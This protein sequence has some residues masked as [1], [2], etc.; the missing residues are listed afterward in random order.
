MSNKVLVINQEGGSIGVPLGVGGQDIR[1]LTWQE[2]DALSQQEREGD[3]IF[4]ITDPE[5][6]FVTLLGMQSIMGKKSFLWPADGRASLRIEQKPVSEATA[7]VGLENGDVWLGRPSGA[8]STH[9]RI[10]FRAGGRTVQAVDDQCVQTISGGTTAVLAGKKT[11]GAANQGATVGPV[12]NLPHR[13]DP[14]ATPT[15]GTLANGD[16]WTTTE[17]IKARINGT[18]RTFYHD[19]NLNIPG[20]GLQLVALRAESGL[21]GTGVDSSNGLGV[22]WGTGATQVPRGNDARF[23]D[24]RTPLTHTHLIADLPVAPSGTSNTTQLVRADDS[25]LSNSRAPTNHTHDPIQATTGLTIATGTQN[26]VLGKLTGTGTTPA[27]LALRGTGSLASGLGLGIGTDAPS[28]RTAIEAAP[29]THTHPFGDVNG[30]QTGR[31]LGRTATGTGVA[32]ELDVSAIRTFLGPTGTPSGTTFL[33][34][35]GQWVTPTNTTYTEIG[36]TQIRGATDSTVGLITGRRFKH[37]LDGR[38]H[39]TTQS[40]AAVT[41]TSDTGRTYAVQRAATGDALVVN[42]PWVAG[43]GTPSFTAVSGGPTAAASPA[44]GAGFTVPFVEQETTGQVTIINRTITLPSLGTGTNDA[45]AGNHDHDGRYPR[46]DLAGNLAIANARRLIANIGANTGGGT[47]GDGLTATQRTN[48]RALIGA[49]TGAGTL[50]G[51]TAITNRTTVLTTSPGSAAAPSVDVHTNLVP[52]HPLATNCF[53]MTNG[54]AATTANVWANQ[55]TVRTALGL[56]SPAWSSFGADTANVPQIATALNTTANRLVAT[57]ASG[58]LIP[59]PAITGSSATRPVWIDANGVLQ[60]ASEYPTPGGGGAQVNDLAAHD[61]TFGQ[62]HHNGSSTFASRADHRHSIPTPGNAALTLRINGGTIAAPSWTTIASNFTAN[63]G[64]A[65]NYDITRGQLQIGVFGT[66]AIGSTQLPVHI[67][68]NGVATAITQANLRI[69]LFGTAAIGGLNQPIHLAAN[70]VPTLCNAYPTVNNVTA[71]FQMNGVNLTSFTLNTATAPTVNIP[72]PS[73]PTTNNDW[74]LRTSGTEGGTRA[75]AALRRLPQVDTRDVDQPPNHA[76]FAN[77]GLYCDFKNNT[78]SGLSDGGTFTGVVT[79]VRWPNNTGG[80]SHQLG[81][82]DNGNL[83]IRNA[84]AQTASWGGWSRFTRNVPDP[85]VTDGAWVLRT[86]GT[87]R[88]WETAPTPGGGGITSVALRGDPGLQG[89]GTTA[90][91]LGVDWRN[92]PR[93]LRGTTTTAATGAGNEIKIVNLEPPYTGQLAPNPGDILALTYTNGNTIASA[94]TATGLQLQFANGT[95]FHVRTTGGVSPTVTGGLATA[96]INTGAAHVSAGRTALYYFDGTFWII[97]TSGIITNTTYSVISEAEVRDTTVPTGR[98]MTG[99]RFEQGFNSRF[100]GKFDDSF[101]IPRESGQYVLTTGVQK[102]GLVFA[103]ANT[104]VID[105]GVRGNGNLRVVV[106]YQPNVITVNTN[107]FLFGVGPGT[108]AFHA[109]KMIYGLGST[110]TEI[111][112]W[113]FYSYGAGSNAQILPVPNTVSISGRRTIVDA[114]RNVIKINGIEVGR[115]PNVLTFEL[116]VGRTLAL[117]TRRDDAAYNTNRFA[118]MIYSCQ[119]YNGNTGVLLRN[120]IAVPQGSTQFSSTPAPSNCFWCTESNQYYEGVGGTIALGI[121]EDNQAQWT[122]APTGGGSSGIENFTVNA[123]APLT[124]TNNGVINATGG[125]LTL[126]FPIGVVTASSGATASIRAGLNQTGGLTGANNTFFGTGAGRSHTSGQ[127]NTGVGIDTLGAISGASGADRRNTAIGWRA[128]AVGTGIIDGTFVGANAGM[129][130]TSGINNTL[131]G[132]MAGRGFTTSANNIALGFSAGRW[133][134]GTLTTD[135]AQKTTGTTNSVYIGNNTRT[136]G[137]AQTTVIDNEIVIGHNVQGHGSNS[138]T[139]GS[140]AIPN[141]NIRLGGKTLVNEG[142][143]ANTVPVNNISPVHHL[144]RDEYDALTPAQR[145]NGTIYLV[146]ENTIPATGI[147]QVV[148][149]GTGLQGNGT[150]GQPLAITNPVPAGTTQT[151]G[152]FLRSNG[153][154]P[155]TWASVA[156]PE[157]ICRYLT[158]GT[159]SVNIPVTGTYKITVIGGG[160]GARGHGT[161]NTAMPGGGAGGQLIWIGQLN[162]GNYVCAVGAGGAGAGN[163]TTHANGGISS[164]T[165]NANNVLTA[166]GGNRS[167]ASAASGA[168]GTGGTAIRTGNEG[169]MVWSTTGQAGG[170]GAVAVN[171]SRA[172]RGGSTILGG[173]GDGGSGGTVAAVSAGVSGTGFGSGGG[174][175]SGNFTGGAGAPGV[176]IIES[177]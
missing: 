8:E 104:N 121:V 117:G 171:A 132:S 131:I 147:T 40:Q 93:I 16:I 148:I 11:F 83:W 49:G 56:Q 46:H 78:R 139:I 65:R 32:Q 89:N 13:V 156:L 110:M 102:Y 118:G 151:N 29:A 98:L 129:N 2:Y 70:G 111:N 99:Q 124:V 173:G 145:N 103:G 158:P 135:A 138:L 105:T 4:L 38:V 144:N 143:V 157:R 55:A 79:Y 59:Q 107:Q 61:T 27:W 154:S 86:T 125:S 153:T 5:T 47:D 30:I 48:F 101:N 141:A 106:D 174:G 71:Q 19:G 10:Y 84:Q 28:I 90:D 25:R 115:M 94:I 122:P 33:R 108:G 51:V 36:E 176:I 130:N 140:M 164:F 127:E 81:F 3:T 35:D 159:T 133:I 44:F 15:V 80:H 53:L 155:P 109:E 123:T 54:T 41:P 52:A 97:M 169:T 134:A 73:P 161:A 1:T 23:T 45:A 120:F 150:S 149:G 18:T 67:A 26:V 58:H 96:A 175:A 77:A 6:R 87:T 76:D 172:G 166:S 9:R 126:G 160:A 165:I 152:Q 64:T 31:I 162:A 177:V 43:A 14:Q 95:A 85:P 136:G 167:D 91:G 7:T 39:A 100:N 119:I 82:T 75:W 22:E 66:G 20:G 21:Q 170:G 62:S 74:I 128:A 114:D 92:V 112:Q 168:G 34:G 72:I 88:N 163:A 69:G 60:L 37:A 146:N 116:A 57:N 50:T 142:P 17:S 24:A 113:S 63:D 137:T 68:A 12:F 42:V